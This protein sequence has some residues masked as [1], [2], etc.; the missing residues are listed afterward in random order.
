MNALAAALALAARHGLPVFPVAAS[1]VPTC[2]HGFRDAS[3][4]PDVISELWG[5]HPGPLVGFPTGAG[6]VLDA[7]DIDAP[8]H[9]EAAAWWEAN[10][11][12]IPATRTHRTRSGGLHLLFRHAEGMRNSAGRI[13]PGIDVRGEGGYLIW[14]PAAGCAV[15]DRSLRATWPAWLL[16]LA[17]PPPE[18]PRA[19]LVMPAG[20][21]GDTA[22][23][24]G[25]G[26]LR[27]AVERVA[28]AGQGTRNATLNAECFSMARF[29]P[30]VLSAAEV[31]DALATA[32]RHCGLPVREIATT[33]ASAL[34]AG[35]AT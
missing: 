14:W 2:P 28:S 24:Y 21:S 1:K 25:L 35:T 17:L 6:T 30:A 16:A 29:I 4:D 34:R 8:R 13:A 20:A 33:L 15:L 22:R 32:A 23:R 27:N 10:R 26:A 18:P 19:A 7:L 9:P 12:A 11:E 31:A 3:A 5:Q